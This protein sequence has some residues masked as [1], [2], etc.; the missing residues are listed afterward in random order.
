MEK[1]VLHFAGFPGAAKAELEKIEEA[2]KERKVLEV[3]VIKEEGR[4]RVYISDSGKIE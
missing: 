1:K 3:E 2:M 4:L